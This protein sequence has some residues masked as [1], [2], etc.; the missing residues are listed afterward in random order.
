MSF[1]CDLPR[2]FVKIGHINIHIFSM[3]KGFQYG[4]Q[5]IATQEIRF[6]G[7]FID[8]AGGIYNFNDFPQ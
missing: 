7:G 4:S 2:Y 1:D 5:T 3:K 8:Y 6:S